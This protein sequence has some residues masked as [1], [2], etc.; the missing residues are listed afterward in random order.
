[1]EPEIET[2]PRRAL[3][4]DEAR[5]IAWRWSSHSNVSARELA[6]LHVW[7]RAQSSVQMVS[8]KLELQTSVAEDLIEASKRSR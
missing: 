1:M 5:N 3:A 2:I 7:V 4:V 8:M 6:D